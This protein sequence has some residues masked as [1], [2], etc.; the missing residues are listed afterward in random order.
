MSCHLAREGQ[1]QSRKAFW[2]PLQGEHSLVRVSTRILTGRVMRCGK[3][4]VHNS[5]ERPLQPLS[6]LKMVP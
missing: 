4:T 5:K 1:A 2:T 6:E 3:E